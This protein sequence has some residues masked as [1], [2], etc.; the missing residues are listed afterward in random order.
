MLK[1][2]NLAM[3]EPE[4]T[5]LPMHQPPFQAWQVTEIC[6]PLPHLHQI[7]EQIILFI[8]NPPKDILSKTTSFES[9]LAS[10]DIS[11]ETK[12]ECHEPLNLND[13]SETLFSV[14]RLKS[15]LY[16]TSSDTPSEAVNSFQDEPLGSGLR[17][18]NSP[19]FQ[20]MLTY[21]LSIHPC[22]LMR[23]L[24]Q[25][26]DLRQDMSDSRARSYVQKNVEKCIHTWVR[27]FFDDFEVCPCALLTF[28]TFL[29]ELQETIIKAPEYNRLYCKLASLLEAK[30][31]ADSALMQRLL[32]GT[33]TSSSVVRLEVD[34]P[35]QLVSYI[36]KGSMAHVF[37]V[38]IP[39]MDALIRGL[40]LPHLRLLS[41]VKAYF[42]FITSLY[43]WVLT[44]I[45]SCASIK[46]RAFLIKHLL[47]ACTELRKLKDFNACFSL[48][49]ALKHPWVLHQKAIWKALKKKYLIMFQ[50]LLSFSDPKNNFSAYFLELDMLNEENN[51]P[52]PFIV[53]HLQLSNMLRNNS[54]TQETIEEWLYNFISLG[55][56]RL[57]LQDAFRIGNLPHPEPFPQLNLPCFN[58]FLAFK[59]DIKMEKNVETS[60]SLFT[61]NVSNTKTLPLQK[62]IKGSSQNNLLFNK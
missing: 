32:L 5:L 42:K 9:N 50:E 40:S 38:S 22:E 24:I 23:S 61:S 2:L 30:T 17:D 57:A 13:D 59:R 49:S 10:I 48:L 3:N 60:S 34:N 29:K 16:Q 39:I 7:M 44:R 20:F 12:K 37:H 54:A 55:Y 43:K 4:K 8:E 21:R 19:F 27:Y 36:H 35:S 15:L 6:G 28:R 46:A 11:K 1:N 56:Y 58:G 62:L 53:I 31:N 52:V 14:F 47:K 18:I 26:F 33:Q 25:A 51:V 41:N 45:E